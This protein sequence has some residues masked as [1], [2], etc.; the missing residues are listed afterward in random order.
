VTKKKVYEGIETAVG[1]NPLPGE[2]GE[3]KSRKGVVGKRRR[4]NLDFGQGC[5][6]LR[7]VRW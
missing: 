6:R 7:T 1:F 2:R 4:F 5:R 3:S